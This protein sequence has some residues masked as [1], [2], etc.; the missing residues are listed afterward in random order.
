LRSRLRLDSRPADLISIPDT[1]LR[2]QDLFV[3]PPANQIAAGGAGSQSAASHGGT[4]G[5][6]LHNSTGPADTAGLV[7]ITQPKDGK[8]GIVVSGSSI[9]DEFPESA[10]ILSG[11]MVYTVYIK[12]GLRKNWV[13]QYC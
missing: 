10:G 12:A 6:E 2:A 11:Q 9:S 3:V 13:L 4:S 8:F 5:P 1:A 7:R